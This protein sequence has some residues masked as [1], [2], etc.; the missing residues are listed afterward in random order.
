MDRRMSRNHP[1]V[2]VEM[3]SSDAIGVSVLVCMLFYV[4]YVIFVLCILVRYATGGSGL[5]QPDTG[6]VFRRL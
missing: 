1:T 5:V 6:I 2:T 4:I 3:P